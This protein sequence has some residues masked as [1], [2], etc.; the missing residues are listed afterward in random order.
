ML[1]LCCHKPV[2]YILIFFRGQNVALEPVRNCNN[3]NSS[4]L[5]AVGLAAITQLARQEPSPGRAS[6]Q[7][8][9]PLRPAATEFPGVLPTDVVVELPSPTHSREHNARYVFEF[10][11]PMLGAN[12]IYG[13]QCGAACSNNFEKYS[14]DGGSK[15]LII[16][17]SPPCERK[18][19]AAT[20]SEKQ[21]K[22][23]HDRLH[24]R[25][26]HSILLMNM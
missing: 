26:S 20:S 7:A 2:S 10:N 21:E 14:L 5:H 9:S 23:I 8:V 16:F 19:E 24:I 6:Q 18:A 1:L 25:V 17:F 13:A 3:N 22:E 15:N 12:M 11:G 4:P